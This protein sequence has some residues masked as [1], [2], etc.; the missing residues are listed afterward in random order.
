MIPAGSQNE[1]VSASGLWRTGAHPPV[2]I[3][4]QGEVEHRDSTGQ[5]GAIVPVMSSG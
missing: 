2:T 4:Y 3:V 5:G 1:F